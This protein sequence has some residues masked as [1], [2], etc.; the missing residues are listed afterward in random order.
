MKEACIYHQEFTKHDSKGKAVNVI[1]SLYEMRK[2]MKKHHISFCHA[3]GAT[4]TAMRHAVK[5]SE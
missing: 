2:K 5:S 4:F 1:D 3:K